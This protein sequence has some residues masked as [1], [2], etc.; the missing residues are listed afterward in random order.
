MEQY[1]PELPVFKLPLIKVSNGAKSAE[2]IDPLVR[3]PITPVAKFS[4]VI[5]LFVPLLP[6]AV[7]LL[8][9]IG[10]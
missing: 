2:L 8:S 5:F 6:I 10:I 3:L 4:I 7:S 9:T 1:A